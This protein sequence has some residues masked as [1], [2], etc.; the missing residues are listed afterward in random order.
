MRKMG[1]TD[2]VLPILILDIIILLC[3]K[4]KHE[5]RI[6]KT[7]RRVEHNIMTFQQMTYFYYSA[8]TL[9]FSKAAQVC[10]VA[11]T[12][13]SKQIQ[14][15]EDELGVMLFNRNSKQL[16]LTAAGDN[17]KIY[18]E[19]IIKLW[20]DSIESTKRIG[21]TAFEK[22]DV[23]VGYW[24]CIESTNLT[25]IFNDFLKSEPNCTLYYTHLTLTG[26]IDCLRKGT[27]DFVI[28]PQAHL[29]TYD[30]IELKKLMEC[31]FG[32]VMKSDHPL[33]RKSILSPLDIVNETFIQRIIA[34]SAGLCNTRQKCW[35]EMGFYPQNFIEVN[36]YK[37]AVMMVSNNMGITLSPEYVE[38]IQSNNLVFRPVEGLY[39]TEAIAIG[40]LP[41]NEKSVV[42][43]MINYFRNIE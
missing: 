35:E 40:Y 11:Q 39:Q 41:K 43:R 17:L 2:R 9:S 1:K 42:D 25:Y 19:R 32:I 3:I 6:I 22:S 24:G 37:S 16:E 14:N 5:Q 34:A 23:I 28:A 31:R 38:E 27:V 15:L 26:I 7:I 29:E 13:V 36:E 18:A 10:Y 21:K 4:E 20:N 30:E 8:K 33:S 12:A